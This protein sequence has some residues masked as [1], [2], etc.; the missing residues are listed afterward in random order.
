MSPLGDFCGFKHSKAL[1]KP[2]I[3]KNYSKNQDF[4]GIAPC[5]SGDKKIFVALQYAQ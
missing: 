2:N 1:Q 5:L 3:Y 4:E